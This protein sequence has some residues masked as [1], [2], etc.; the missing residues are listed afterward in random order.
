MPDEPVHVAYTQYLAET[1]KLPTHD[2]GPEY[3]SEE[4][5]QIALLDFFAVAGNDGQRDWV[6]T[7]TV[8][9]VAES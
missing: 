6:E 1:G 5:A 9:D 2:P 3:S 4:R 7:N 8:G